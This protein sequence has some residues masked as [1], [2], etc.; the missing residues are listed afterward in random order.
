MKYW[1][2]TEQQYHP[3][4]KDVEGEATCITVPTNVIDPNVAADLFDRYYAEFQLCDEL[5]FG[6]GVNEHH[7][8][9][10]C[11]SISPLMTLAVAAR[12]TKRCR[13][14][15]LGTQMVNRTD[16]LRI[17]E[18]IA[19]VDV[20]SRGRLEAGLIKGTSME[21]FA[22]GE[23]PVGM[24]KRFWETHDVVK[25]ALTTRDGSFRWDSDNYHFRSV[26]V[27]PT[28]FQ[29]PHP[30]FWTV[31]G[32]PSS[33]REIGE[34]GY[35][36]AVFGMGIAPA[37]VCYDAYR[38]AYRAKFGKPAPLDRICFHSL[39]VVGPTEAEAHKRA[40]HLF[41]FYRALYRKSTVLSSPPGYSSFKEV[42]KSLR[43][44]K[45]VITDSL[46]VPPPLPECIE[47]GKFIVG[48]PDQVVRR[49]VEIDEQLGGIGHLL[50]QGGGTLS[51]ED[52]ADHLRLMAKEV[53]PRVAEL[54][55]GRESSPA[56]DRSAA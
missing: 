28:P 29:K 16:P 51:F 26:N 43:S 56:L 32:S 25:K 27:V 45:Q 44:G 6:I 4:W 54:L 41:E 47:T 42:A 13:L 22:S 10:S 39:C 40:E 8:S 35:V 34:H 46:G 33:A 49:I 21:V 48:T 36:M 30:P 14:L 19:M 2:F 12:L 23:S 55:K 50:M 15:S 52:T 53:V 5:G 3:A 18:E 24:G 11:M 20:L 7:A 37:R 31:G 9:L 1:Y 38:D 17:A